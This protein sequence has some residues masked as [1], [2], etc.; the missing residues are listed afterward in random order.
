MPL[1]IQFDVRSC[2]P[3]PQETEQGKAILQDDQVGHDGVLQ[4]ACLVRLE[5][6]LSNNKISIQ[7]HL[8]KRL[9]SA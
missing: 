8:K 1:Y 7:L 9:C 6:P 3:L 4:D 5:D 2:V